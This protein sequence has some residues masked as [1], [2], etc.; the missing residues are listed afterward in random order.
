MKYTVDGTD[1]HCCGHGSPTYSCDFQVWYEGTLTDTAAAHDASLS[2]FSG[3]NADARDTFNIETFEHGA[4]VDSHAVSYELCELPSGPGKASL[5]DMSVTSNGAGDF[6]SGLIFWP[7]SY[8][9]TVPF[10]PRGALPGYQFRHL[11]AYAHIRN[12]LITGQ[13]FYESVSSD[14][15][16]AQ[17]LPITGIV[18][19]HDGNQY[20][21]LAAVNI[22][23]RCWQGTLTS[24][25]GT[26]PYENTSVGSSNVATL[27]ADG[28]LS[29]SSLPLWCM[30]AFPGNVTRLGFVYGLTSYDSN[31]VSRS[32]GNGSWSLSSYLDRMTGTGCFTGRCNCHHWDLMTLNCSFNSGSN[33]VEFA[34]QTVQVTRTPGTG[35]PGSDGW[36]YTGTVTGTATAAQDVQTLTGSGG[37]MRPNPHPT[38]LRAF[39]SAKYGTASEFDIDNQVEVDPVSGLNATAI[40][41]H[42]NGLPGID[43]TVTGSSSVGSNGGGFVGITSSANG[44]MNCFQMAGTVTQ[45]DGTT[46]VNSVTFAPLRVTPGNTGGARS[47]AITLEIDPR[48]LS[49]GTENATARDLRSCCNLD[50]DLGFLTKSWLQATPETSSSTPGPSHDPVYLDF[51]TS[52]GGG[53][54]CLSTADKLVSYYWNGYAPKSPPPAENSITSWGWDVTITE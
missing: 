32:L 14:T 18:V 46:F 50:I 52:G 34:G 10:D 8:A 42:L 13:Q 26:M 22:F 15:D 21:N 29:Y 53:S 27:A 38:G 43:V 5:I 36:N 41:A 24:P 39:V 9:S 28:S 4:S 49:A 3:G 44:P 54:S 7:K 20:F 37:D 48:F 19:E 6:T 11:S 25:W 2:Y 17:P 30:D 16:A 31:W 35:G 1:C 40:V 47:A 12:A 45:S 23:N 51:D 33:P